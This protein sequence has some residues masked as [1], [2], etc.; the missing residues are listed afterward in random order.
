MTAFIDTNVL[1]YAQGTG[2]KSEVART[3]I[4]TGGVI[5][6]QVLNEFVAVLRRKFGFDWDVVAEAVADV[7]AALDPVRPVD[8]STHT[9]A[10]A[11][12]RSYGFNFYDSLIVAAA[13]EAGCDTLLT[14]D[15]Q[16]GQ[17]IESLTVVNPF[18]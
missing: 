5:S 8:I 4:L 16:A 17:R 10:M 12:A 2:D 11:L 15:L 6:V 9:E 18:A 1:I 13:L 14:E 7:R 3:V